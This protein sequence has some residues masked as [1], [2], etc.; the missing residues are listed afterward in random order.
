M[1]SGNARLVSGMSV[2]GV[3]N[4]VRGQFPTDTPD[5]VWGCRE[6]GAG[7]GEAPG[8]YS[9]TCQCRPFLT[10]TIPAGRSLVLWQQTMEASCRQ[11][12]CRCPSHI[13][14]DVTGTAP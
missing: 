11:R 5:I 10:M 4:D 3:G 1:L 12:G 9:L 14:A 8:L 13:F 7:R 2:D 6:F